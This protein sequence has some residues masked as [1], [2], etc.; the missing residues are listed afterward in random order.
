M[1]IDDF[2]QQPGQKELLLKD[3]ILESVHVSLPGE[4]ISYN[5]NNRT[6]KIQLVIRNWKS[7]DNPPI[8]TD[9]PVFFPGNIVFPVSVGDGC[10]VVFADKCIDAW[11]ENGGVSSPVSAR[12]HSLS[13]GFAFVGFSSKK[14]LNI[15][16][17]I[18]DKI[19]DLERRIEALEVS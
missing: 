8:L 5:S 2:I 14:N 13:D 9:V 17:N 12:N 6:A 11:F 16:T 7:F 15:G 4:I 10:L 1:K 18:L 3:S 19:A